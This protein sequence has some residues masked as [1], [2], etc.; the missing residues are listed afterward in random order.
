MSFS[1]LIDDPSIPR[2]GQQVVAEGYTIAAV[3]RCQC[4]AGGTFVALTMVVSPAGTVAPANICA[5]C[6][7]PYNI[8]GMRLDA[9]GRL[10]F[11]IGVLSTDS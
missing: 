3:T 8:Q 11:A 9:N 6:R 10:T 5:K 7:T 2:V 1:S 4:E